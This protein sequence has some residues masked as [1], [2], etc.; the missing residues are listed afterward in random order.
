MSTT[1]RISGREYCHVV[2]AHF[3]LDEALGLDLC[4]VFPDRTVPQGIEHYSTQLEAGYENYL[5][6]HDTEW[7][8]WAIFKTDTNI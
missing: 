6:S 1:R 7:Y 8:D 3:R 2:L 4:D 5:N